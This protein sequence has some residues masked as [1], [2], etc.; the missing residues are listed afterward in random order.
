MIHEVKCDSVCKE[1][2]TSVC[3]SECANV[4][5]MLEC[6]NWV[7]WGGGECQ[8]LRDRG[9]SLSLGYRQTHFII[10]MFYVSVQVLLKYYLCLFPG[11]DLTLFVYST[12]YYR[13]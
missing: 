9:V 11:T 6:C 5:V 7:I 3:H 13:Y 8:Y 10:A 12:L 2:W 1:L 4:G